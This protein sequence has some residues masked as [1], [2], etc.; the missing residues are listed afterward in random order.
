MQ[1]LMSLPPQH[2]QL[3]RRDPLQTQSDRAVGAYLVPREGGRPLG[4]LDG[5][6]H[7]RVIFEADD[8]AEVAKK[9]SSSDAWV[10]LTKQV[11]AQMKG[12]R[13][14]IAAAERRISRI[15]DARQELSALAETIKPQVDSLENF[16]IQ[17]KAQLTRSEEK[18]G[19]VNETMQKGISELN[20]V[21]DRRFEVLEQL[22]SGQRSMYEANQLWRSQV[23]QLQDKAQKNT[24]AITAVSAMQKMMRK[25]QADMQDMQTRM[26]SANE[27]DLT[28]VN[29][30]IDSIY[31][32]QTEIGDATEALQT[33]VQT[34]E[35]AIKE[36]QRL[37]DMFDTNFRERIHDL[38]EWPGV[39]SQRMDAF[40]ARMSQ[41]DA[42]VLEATTVTVQTKR[43]LDTFIKTQY[44]MM[45]R[46]ARLS[47]AGRTQ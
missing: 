29:Q 34:N 37:I 32:L 22:N 6:D 4:S 46:C 36:S 38:E 40:E 2:R 5:S 27:G 35:D 1:Q 17:T 28:D 20:T 30:R 7:P 16:V 39:L 10:A 19:E 31:E 18:Q 47:V 8:I 14:Q 44:K 43:A 12:I 25:T 24:E 15:T 26:L 21:I 9:L 11:T 23:D 33:Q 3:L 41:W 13:Q 45:S 42:Q